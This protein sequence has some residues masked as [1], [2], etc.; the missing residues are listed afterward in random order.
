MLDPRGVVPGAAEMDRAAGRARARPTTRLRPGDAA[1]PGRGRR[2]AGAAAGQ[3]AVEAAFANLELRAVEMAENIERSQRGNGSLF[4][5]FALARQ[6]QRL[7]G[8]KA[9]VYFSEGLQVPNQLEPL[10][11][12][13]VSEANRAN[14]SIYSVDARG[15]R[16]TSDFDRTRT[17]LAKSRETV[18]PPGAV[19]RRARRHPRGRARRRG[20]RGRD[21]HERAG[22]AGRASPTAPAAA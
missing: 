18:R 5:L 4:G 11:R 21:H 2:G 1:V 3:A 13:V 14:L 6:Q 10:Y 19:A 20:G 16:T 22:H 17:D 15:L 9:I 12:S 8:R 7:A